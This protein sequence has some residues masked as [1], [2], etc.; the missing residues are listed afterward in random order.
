MRPITVTPRRQRG[1]SGGNG[2]AH[3][4]V[5]PGR[6]ARSSP[7]RGMRE[8]FTRKKALQSPR[9]TSSWERKDSSF[10]SPLPHSFPLAMKSDSTG[11][12]TSGHA[13][14]SPKLVSAAP[15]GDS[16]AP[17]TSQDPV[18]EENKRL[19]RLERDLRRRVKSLLWRELPQCRGSQQWVDYLTSLKEVLQ[20]LEALRSAASFQ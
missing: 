8:A 12:T 2:E 5:C 1:A 11:A 7:S 14:A 20:M 3:T 16:K 19:R 18:P 10:P 13:S 4:C 6:S 17:E 9:R 15:F